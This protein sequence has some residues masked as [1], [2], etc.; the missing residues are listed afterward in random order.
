MLQNPIGILQTNT[1]VPGSFALSQNFPNPF[2]PTT[3]IKFQIPKS[4]LIKLIIYDALGREVQTL[5][6]EQLSPG[7]YQAD[8]DGTNLS[9]GIYYYKLESADYTETKKMVLI[10]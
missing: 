6:N 9:S 2:N 10:K 4:G 1:E 7:T 8:F 3:K 5:V